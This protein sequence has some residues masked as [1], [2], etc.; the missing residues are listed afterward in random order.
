MLAEHTFWEKATSIHVYCLPGRRGGERCA[1][2]WHDLARRDDAG[3]AARA[4]TD[5]ELGLA[6]AHHKAMFSRESDSNGGRID[7]EAA[8][9][10]SPRLAPSGA[11][12]EVLADDCAGMPASGMPLDEDEPFSALMER[13]AVIEE[14]VHSRT[15]V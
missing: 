5:R 14:R 10:G 12:Q 2:H 7:C 3:I 4:V 9:S 15:D 8:I 1:G 13:C 6:V 11:A